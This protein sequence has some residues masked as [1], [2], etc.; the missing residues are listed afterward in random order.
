MIEWSHKRITLV[1]IVVLFWDT[2][3]S[4][5]KDNN[6][7]S[8]YNSSVFSFSDCKLCQVEKDNRLFE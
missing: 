4:Y 1:Y 7:S 5:L 3:R 2:N 8:L 6:L